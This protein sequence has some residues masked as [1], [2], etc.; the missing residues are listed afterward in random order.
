MKLSVPIYRLK[1]NARLLSRRDSIPLHE[2][3]DRLASQEGYVS[4]SLLAAQLSRA[5][6][7]G[8]LLA[9]FKSG[10]LVLLAARPG[11]G[12]T[13]LGLEIAV[14]AMASGYR[15]F[16]FTLEYTTLDIHRL[17]TDIDRNPAELGDRFTLDTSDAIC[18]DYMIE[19]LSNMPSKTVAV[20]DYLQLLDQQRSKPDLE[21]QLS[22][23]ESFARESGNILVFLSQ[24][25]RSFEISQREFPDPGDLRLPNPIDLDR[26]TKTCFLNNGELRV[27]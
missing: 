6:A 9:G 23:L 11:H 14:E 13:Q 20:V 27:S 1:R 25:D 4:W 5:P 26:F 21:A 22:T 17:F 7:A 18:A 15:A 16:F 8:R 10:D 19:C 3:L 24:V 12:K 2:A